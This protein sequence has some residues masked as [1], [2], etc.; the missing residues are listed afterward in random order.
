MIIKI[1][2]RHLWP[3]LVLFSVFLFLHHSL[4]KFHNWA[5]GDFW[6]VIGFLIINGC[7]GAVTIMFLTQLFIW[8]LLHKNVCMDV[9]GFGVI[10]CVVYRIRKTMQHKNW[11]LIFI[12]FMCSLVK[13]RE[14]QTPKWRLGLNLTY[15]CFGQIRNR[16]RYL[17]VLGSNLSFKYQN[18]P[19]LFRSNW[20][21]G[22]KI[23]SLNKCTRIV[24]REAKHHYADYM[25]YSPIK[26]IIGNIKIFREFIMF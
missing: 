4:H 8:Y 15:Y 14:K 16:R 7:E 23:S 1:Y 20:K 6:Q 11:L 3:D 17:R 13:W 2:Y 19:C 22:S 21:I 25:P 26:I 24:F 9:G 12:C 10:F 5:F 18:I